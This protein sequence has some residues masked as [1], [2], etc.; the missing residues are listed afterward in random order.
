MGLIDAV[1]TFLFLGCSGE[2]LA[3]GL[4]EGMAFV[5]NVDANLLRD[6]SEDLLLCATAAG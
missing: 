2:D 4:V 5:R 6:E 3:K 1:D